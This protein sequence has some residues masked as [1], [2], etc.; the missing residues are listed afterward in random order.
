MEKHKT[1]RPDWSVKREVVEIIS[2]DESYETL[3]GVEISEEEEGFFRLYE[4]PLFTENLQWGDLIHAERSGEGVLWFLQF[5]ERPDYDHRTNFLSRELA[6]TG[7][8]SFVE[9]N[10]DHLKKL[11]DAGGFWQLDMGGMLTTI[12]PNGFHWELSE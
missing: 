11:M 7:N 10:Q 5:V 3:G 6:G 2:D 12:V 4:T 9:K 1:W 8:N